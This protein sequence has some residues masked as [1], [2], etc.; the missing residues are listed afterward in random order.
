MLLHIGIRSL[1]GGV[2]AAGQVLGNGNAKNIF[3]LTEGFQPLAHV[4]TGRS[5]SALVVL[6]IF[7]HGRHIQIGIIHIFFVGSH[8]HG[9]G[10]IIHSR[11]GQDICRRVCYNSKFHK[12]TSFCSLSSVSQ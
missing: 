6:Q 1:L 9:H 8:L 3:R 5:G 4:G 10:G 7:H 11:Q 12:G 2:I